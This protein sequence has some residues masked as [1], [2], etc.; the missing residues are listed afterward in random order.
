M[1]ARDEDRECQSPL[2]VGK[3]T[4]MTRKSTKMDLRTLLR[5]R[6]MRATPARLAVCDV[7]SKAEA[8]LTHAEVSKL[9]APRDFDQTTVFRNLADL[10]E[11]R[12]IRRIEVGDHVYRF[13]WQAG[14]DA[15]ALHAHFF[16][17]DCGEVTCLTDLPSV[18]SAAVRRAGKNVIHDV[19]EVL[20]KGHCSSCES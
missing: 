10:V 17:V 6:G 2:L 13:E 19:T 8:P 16:C 4:V 14:G 18:A 1:L 3:S 20:Y 5:E 7:L 12:V 11:A 9:L 15:D